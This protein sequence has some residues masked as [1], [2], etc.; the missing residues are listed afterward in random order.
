[1]AFETSQ[2]HHLTIGGI[3]F[4]IYILWD[5]I[6]RELLRLAMGFLVLAPIFRF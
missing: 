3:F 1:M 2:K 6:T 5:A 4:V